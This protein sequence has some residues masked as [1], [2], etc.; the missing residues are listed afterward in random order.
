[1]C[2]IDYIYYLICAIWCNFPLNNT[3]MSRVVRVVPSSLY[4]VHTT[5]S[6]DF[7]GLSSSPFESSNLLHR[8]QMGENVIIGVIDT[9]THLYPTLKQPPNIYTSQVVGET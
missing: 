7:L 4:K 5:R 2:A 6:W 9:G 8:A 3:E 1:M